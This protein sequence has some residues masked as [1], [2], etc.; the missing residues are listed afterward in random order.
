[1]AMLIVSCSSDE[2]ET[3]PEEVMEEALRNL[4][5]IRNTVDPLFLESANFEDFSSHFNEI[6]SLEGVK[7]AW[8]ED[9]TLFVKIDNGGII[10][11]TFV[12]DEDDTPLDYDSFLS[13]VNNSSRFSTRAESDVELCENTKVLVLN[14]QSNDISRDLYKEGYKNIEEAIKMTSAYSSFDYKEANEFTLDFLKNDISEYGI[15]Y[16]ITH[17]VY[18][19]KQNKHWIATGE[20][21][22]DKLNSLRE[23]YNAWHQERVAIVYLNERRNLINRENES[24]VFSVPYICIC[25]DFIKEDMKCLFSDNSILF[26]TACQSLKGND[27]LWKAFREKNLG[28]Y[29]GYTDN[30][31]VGKIAG[32][33]FIDNLFISNQPVKVVYE[34]LP[35]KLKYYKS[36]TLKCFPE[37]CSIS[38]YDYSSDVTMGGIVDLG[39]SVKWA[40]QNLGATKPSQL[41]T[42][43][44]MD[45]ILTPLSNDILN[46][47]EEYKEVY[48]DGKINI[49]GSKYDPVYS[50]YGGR[51]RMPSLEEV[52][53]LVSNCKIE[54]VLIDEVA[55]LKLTGPN[56]NSIFLPTYTDKQESYGYVTYSLELTLYATGTNTTNF[57]LDC[58]YLYGGIPH[59]SIVEPWYKIDY[60]IGDKAFIRPVCK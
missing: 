13:D 34:N 41:G 53:E 47:N 7:E 51:W 9:S 38:L 21:A 37:N 28:C 23:W 57:A 52:K 14:Q 26:I 32:V 49:C 4:E 25:E 19:A 60:E 16:V 35:T 39:L 31:S 58:A 36:A 2:E 20:V 54:P 33:V 56:K 18:S 17:G 24:K 46:R 40:S 11:W 3:V 6:K 30:N 5:S 44:K 48:S 10:F 12:T 22:F 43:F 27:N 55:G 45:D 15:I 42:I 29:L 1:M 50:Q 59:V 8:T